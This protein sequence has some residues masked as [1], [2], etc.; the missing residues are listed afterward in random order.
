MKK[1]LRILLGFGLVLL[2]I[3]G[4]ILPV[5]PGW[6]FLIPG[7]TILAEHFPWLDRHLNRIIAWGKERLR[8]E[9]RKE[10]LQ[11]D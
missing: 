3:V 2:G 10:K 9:S 11:R 4:I 8:K 5:M 1:T 6:I 7:L